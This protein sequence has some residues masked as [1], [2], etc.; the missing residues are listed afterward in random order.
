M[1]TNHKH[2][3]AAIALLTLGAAI[4]A[5]LARWPMTTA[6]ASTGASSAPTQPAAQGERKVLYWYDPMV[7]QHK[8]DQP[9]KSPFMDMQLV[10]KYADET[11]AGSVSV[12]PRLAQSLG[13]RTAVVES[14]ATGAVLEVPSSLQLNERDVA[15]VQA[16]TEGFVQS[17]A[18]LAPGDVVK[19]GQT[20]AEL[21][22]PQ[23]A[24][25][26]QEFLA[27]RATGEAAL[28]AAARQRL[29]WLGMPDALIRNVERSGQVHAVTAVRAP[30]GGLVRELAVR[31]GMTVAPGMTLARIS[32]LSTVWLEAAVPETQA[33]A[34][35]T[36]SAVEVKLPAYPGETL[37]GKV[38]AILPEA[39]A[40]TRTLRIR[41]ELPNPQG[42]LRDGMFATARFQAP[43]QEM[44]VLP[45]E[46]VIRT[47]RRAVVYLVD[48][49]GR[50][51]PVQ[52]EIGRDL[53]DRLEVL[54]GLQ[55][56]QEVVASGQFLIDSEASMQGLLPRQAGGSNTGAA[57][58]AV[59]AAVGKVVELTGSEIT[60]DHGPVPSLQW[61]AMEMAFKLPR[62]DA[63]PGV[64]VGDTV[65]FEFV[66]T[67]DG[68]EIRSLQREA[69]R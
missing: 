14:K 10:P 43:E 54:S 64:K 25:A 2:A 5:G 27:V 66:Q 15:I 65:R 69:A 4:G 22:V 38:A 3:I 39:D 20:I 61:G 19:A 1:K 48:G 37:T 56:G 18:P 46:A 24:G 40:R 42:R 6:A 21:L 47:G 53:G 67:D 11:A 49:P 29:V 31:R 52:V 58:V 44:L 34:A 63:A 41:I 12:D 60:L 28:T 50:Y 51:R 57:E 23:W 68:F 36:G 9:G 62:P 17:V 59:H 8:F 13:W 26:Q 33:W 45:A 35:R 30:I 55:A 16:R 7:P 32:G